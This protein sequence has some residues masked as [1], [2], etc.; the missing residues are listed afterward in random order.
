MIYIYVCTLKGGCVLCVCVEN[1]SHVNAFLFS[2]KPWKVFL[3]IPETS[4]S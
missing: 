1:V 4:S 2:G 3:V